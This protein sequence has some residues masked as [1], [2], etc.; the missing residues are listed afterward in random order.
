MFATSVGRKS[1][2]SKIGTPLSPSTASSSKRL[3]TM[4]KVGNLKR[5]KVLVDDTMFLHAEY[6]SPVQCY[7][8]VFGSFNVCLGFCL[9]CIIMTCFFYAF[10]MYGNIC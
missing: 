6:V 7:V 5:R 3:R 2:F 9:L 10:L 8:S 1:Q 4:P